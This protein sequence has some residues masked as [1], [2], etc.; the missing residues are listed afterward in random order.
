MNEEYQCLVHSFDPFVE[1]D[2]FKALRA[3][4]PESEKAVSLNVNSKWVFHKLGIVGEI[5]KEQTNLKM[6]SMMTLNEILVYTK[7]KDQVI[8]K[9]N[10]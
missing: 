6:G 10:F 8:G 5:E 1:A 2:G 7:L 4:R 3:T 9:L